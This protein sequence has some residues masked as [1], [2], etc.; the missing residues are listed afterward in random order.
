MEK[1]SSQRSIEIRRISYAEILD[2][3]RSAALLAEYSA[4]CSIPE[5]GIPNPQRE[6]YE[7]ME[8]SGL[9]Q[10]FG[11]FA[12]EGLVGFATILLFVLP[13]YGRKI[14]NVESL[15]VTKEHRPGRY[16][17]DHIEA[18]AKAESCCGVLYNA[19]RGSQLEKL[20]SLIPK[21]KRTN[22]VF[23]WSAA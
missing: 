22:S 7:H 2:D 14:A 17:L 3:P 5:I 11:V 4:E 19:R 13:H 9:M 20:L 21:Y 23:L 6:T 10:S 16:L 1:S 12:E 8:K 18:H 15:F